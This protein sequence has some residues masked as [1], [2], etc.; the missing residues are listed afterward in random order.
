M[1]K[2]AKMSERQPIIKSRCFFG[3]HNK[4]R[5][6]LPTSNYDRCAE[7]ISESTNPLVPN[8]VIRRLRAIGLILGSCAWTQIVVPIIK[9]VAVVVVDVGRMASAKNDSVHKDA[10][11]SSLDD[12][13]SRCVEGVLFTVPLRVPVELHQVVEMPRADKA[14]QSSGQRNDAIARIGWLNNSMALYL[15]FH[16]GHF[17]QAEAPYRGA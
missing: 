17:T 12:N 5:Y 16:L 1:S 7:F 8:R 6:D 13:P 2:F 9:A 14:I 10:L 4:G 15:A 11:L 3:G